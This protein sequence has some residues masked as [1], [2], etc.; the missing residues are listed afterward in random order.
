MDKINPDSARDG[1][2]F[3]CFGTGTGTG[4]APIHTGN[5]NEALFWFS[6]GYVVLHVLHG[7]VVSDARTGGAEP[8]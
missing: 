3:E 5:P 6:L 4:T 2:G 8:C 1:W 7:R